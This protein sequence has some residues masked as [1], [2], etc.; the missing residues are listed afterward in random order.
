MITPKY[1]YI[2]LQF[3]FKEQNLLMHELKHQTFVL[4]EEN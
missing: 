3:Y 1:I 4:K 2:Y